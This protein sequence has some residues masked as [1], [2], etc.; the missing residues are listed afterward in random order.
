MAMHA[1]VMSVSDVSVSATFM[2]SWSST[3]QQLNRGK[4]YLGLWFWRA[5]VHPHR[6]GIGRALRV[7]TGSWRDWSHLVDQEVNRK[8][9]DPGRYIFKNPITCCLLWKTRFQL[10]KS[11]QTSEQ[12]VPPAGE[13]KIKNT[14]WW[15]DI[16]IQTVLYIHT[17]LK[18]F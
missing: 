17:Q 9:Q 5:E 12:Q 10:L 8:E 11:P 7:A 13:S 16:Q 14:S 15:K 4:A 6:E 3:H 2:S 1:L 18:C